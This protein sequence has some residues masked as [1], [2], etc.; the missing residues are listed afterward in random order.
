LVAVEGLAEYEASL[1]K[2]TSNSDWIAAINK[3]HGLLGD[4][5]I[6]DQI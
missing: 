4:G 2:L 6:A 3:A 1:N 5:S